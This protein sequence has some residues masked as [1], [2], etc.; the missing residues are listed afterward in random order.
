VVSIP[1]CHAGDP[2]SIPGNGVKYFSLFFYV[3]RWTHLIRPRPRQPRPCGVGASLSIRFRTPAAAES[4]SSAVLPNRCVNLHR[5]LQ[6]RRTTDPLHPPK[7]RRRAMAAV[8][9]EPDPSQDP[10]TASSSAVAA[11]GVGGPNPCCAKVSEPLSVQI[12]PC[13]L[14]LSPVRSGS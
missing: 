1:A 9:P 4:D 11:T 12:S 6:P 14:F 13:I 2:G 7:S 5:L 10:P 8:V 3:R